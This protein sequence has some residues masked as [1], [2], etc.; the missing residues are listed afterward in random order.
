MKKIVFVTGTRAD[1]GKL[2][3]LIKITQESK[4][5]EVHIFATGMHLNS[6]YG[7]TVNEIYKSGF[8]NIHQFINHNDNNITM[9]K[10]LSKTI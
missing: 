6:K 5:F 9:D 7:K 3:S 1:F 8:Q 2:K 4:N 10:I